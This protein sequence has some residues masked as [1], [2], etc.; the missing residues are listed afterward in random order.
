MVPQIHA[1]HCY[2]LEKQKVNSPYWNEANSALR[3]RDVV[4]TRSVVLGACGSSSHGDMS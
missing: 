2:A 3:R 1:V 4:V